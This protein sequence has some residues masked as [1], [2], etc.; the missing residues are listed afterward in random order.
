MAKTSLDRIL[1]EASNEILRRVP[2]HK[3]RNIALGLYSKE[4]TARYISEIQEVRSFVKLIESIY[5]EDL[6]GKFSTEWR[7]GKPYN[8]YFNVFWEELDIEKVKE[9]V[10]PKPLSK[11]EKL[12]LKA[13]GKTRKIN[14]PLKGKT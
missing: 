2:E 8:I 6:E 10:P 4:E 9:Y 14:L 5:I 11:E 3:Q 1:D 13:E 7:G 12:K